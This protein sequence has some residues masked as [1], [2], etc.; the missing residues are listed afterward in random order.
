MCVP[1]KRFIVCF[2]APLCPK[3]LKIHVDIQSNPLNGFP[4]NGSI[5]LLVHA[6]AS[7]ISVQSSPLT[8]TPSGQEKSVT[9]SKC[10][11]N[12]LIFIYNRPFGTCQNCHCKR[13]VTVTG[14][15]VSGEIC[16]NAKRLAY[17]KCNM[18]FGS[19]RRVAYSKSAGGDTLMTSANF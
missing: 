11:C 5:W 10:H 9:V 15:T 1:H 7:P 8:V 19:T 17:S 12:Q 3:L 13:G 14:V 2:P 4:D 18:A 16:T 6:L